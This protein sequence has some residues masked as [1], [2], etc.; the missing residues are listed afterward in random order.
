MY[1]GKSVESALLSSAFQNRPCFQVQSGLFVF[2]RQVFFSAPAG[3]IAGDLVFLNKILYL[4]LVKY[5]VDKLVLK[6]FLNGRHAGCYM[7]KYPKH[8]GVN[9]HNGALD[10]GN[11]NW[12]LQQYQ[13]TGFNL[14]NLFLVTRPGNLSLSFT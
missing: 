5:K 9:F 8:V 10:E 3:E 11:E 13:I 4:Y 14:L 2:K 12:Y 7:F 1:I 6:W